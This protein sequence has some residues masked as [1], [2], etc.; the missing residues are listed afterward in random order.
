MKYKKSIKNTSLGWGQLRNEEGEMW[1][2]PPIF[3]GEKITFIDN[4]K[5]LFYPKKFFLYGYIKRGIR[6]ARKAGNKPRI[7]DI[8]CGTG[9]AVI[10]MKKM[11]GR[12]V[13][14]IGVDVLELQIDAAQIQAKEHGV[15]AEFL[16]YDGKTLP[17]SDESVDVI[18][19]SDVLGHV[20]DVPSW[21]REV[22]RVLRPGGVISMFSESKLG[23]HA[24]IRNYLL[25]HGLNTDPHAKFHIS[26]YS[27]EELKTLLYNSGFYI[28][29]MYSVFWAKFFV[30]PDELYPAFKSQ[31]NFLFLKTI[32]A[33]L[34]YVK[35]YTKPFSLALSEL[36]G[37]FEILIVGR[38]IE[39]Q[40]YIIYAFKDKV[41]VNTEEKNTITKFTS[42][43]ISLEIP[44]TARDIIE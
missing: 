26:L 33:M 4:F 24:Y 27:K 19:T 14:V 1:D 16:W 12:S 9:G 36:Y 34:N 6:L 35:V 32:N 3:V 31:K 22:N 5:L 15:W 18:Y 17:F 23:R 40:G 38:W 42:V 11:F 7:V 44:T 28:K 30:H 2:A 39:S 20:E 41:P 43:P 37:L 8:G 10:D 25:K 29:K 21:L 13:E